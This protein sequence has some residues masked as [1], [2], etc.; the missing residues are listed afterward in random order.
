MK[1]IILILSF[2]FLFSIFSISTKASE[3]WDSI[4]NCMVDTDTFIH[5]DDLFV[6][7]NDTDTI[8]ATRVI[9]FTGIITPSPTVE[10]IETRNGITYRGTLSLT[11]YIYMNNTTRATYKGTLYPVS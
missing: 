7:N 5:T 9:S 8:S 6:Y 11:Q 1:K 2:F 10:A 3:D 4:T